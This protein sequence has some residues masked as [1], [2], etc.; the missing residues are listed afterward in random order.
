MN[1]LD[2]DASKNF[3]KEIKIK[4]NKNKLKIKIMVKKLSARPNDVSPPGLLKKT[5]KYIQITHENLSNADIS[6]AYI[7]F[8][9]EKSWL[10]QNNEN[11]NNVVLLRYNEKWEELETEY[12]NFDNTY[13]YFKAKSNGL[14]YFAIGTKTPVAIE[15]EQQDE[16]TTP[17]EG[18][19]P[20]GDETQKK[21]KPVQTDTLIVQK[22]DETKKSPLVTLKRIVMLLVI[23]ALGIFI[24]FKYKKKKEQE[25]LFKNAQF[26]F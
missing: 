12:Y 8:A 9:V 24:Y 26:A 21:D 19:A 20:D 13:Y 18:D 16:G 3:I 23:I 7:D 1:K 11:K 14:S 10:M 6:E 2:F 25:S 22:D 4:A 5:Y 17:V 15:D